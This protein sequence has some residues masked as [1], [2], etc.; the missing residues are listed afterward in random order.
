M[1]KS[2]LNLKLVSLTSASLSKAIT[3]KERGFKGAVEARAAVTVAMVT[4]VE[5]LDI[6]VG[7]G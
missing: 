7:F 1:L 6:A 2:R 4:G 5:S 3:S